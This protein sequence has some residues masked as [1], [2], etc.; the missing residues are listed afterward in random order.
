MKIADTLLS[1]MNAGVVGVGTIRE[2][3]GAQFIFQGFM[4][5][6]QNNDQNTNKI[7]VDERWSRR[8]STI[9]EVDGAQ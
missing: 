7:G 8:C 5:A 4:I 9:R 6:H 1:W 3:D 2:V